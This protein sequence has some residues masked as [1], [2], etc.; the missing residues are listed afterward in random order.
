ME[1]YEVQ[2]GRRKED[3]GDKSTYKR[4]PPPELVEAIK[5]ELHS[6]VKQEVKSALDKKDK[7][8]V[9]GVA[10]GIPTI[11]GSV[12]YF[13]YGFNPN[14]GAVNTK[15]ITPSENG[16]AVI[17]ERVSNNKESI[18]DVEKDVKSI[19][20]RLQIQES[21]LQAHIASQTQQMKSLNDK[22]D[23]VIGKLP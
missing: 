11:L 21:A 10:A 5:K 20:A 1:S 22:L 3:N 17:V 23:I 12:L 19:D 14:T 16:Q 4:V 18:K 7:A 15:A 2:G 13:L 8:K 9:A 6:E